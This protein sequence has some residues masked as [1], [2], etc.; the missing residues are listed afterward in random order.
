MGNCADPGNANRDGLIGIDSM[1]GQKDLLSLD[2]MKLY[3]QVLKSSIF[4]EA[5]LI[6]KVP[7]KDQY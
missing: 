7:I 3:D 2:K 6:T 1:G 4:L 5:A